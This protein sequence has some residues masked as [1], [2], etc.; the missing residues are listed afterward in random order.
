LYNTVTSSLNASTMS[1]TPVVKLPEPKTPIV[2]SKTYDVGDWKINTTTSSI[3]P[4]SVADDMQKDLGIP[5]PEI[6]FALNALELVHSSGWTYRFDALDALK[7]V[8][9][10]ELEPGDGGV[11]VRYADEWAKNRTEPGT[12]TPMPVI[13]VM[14]PF[15]WT[16]TT[17]YTGH[18]PSSTEGSPAFKL[19]DPEEPTHKINMQ[20]LTRPDP[21]LFFSEIPL[22]EDELHDNGSSQLT[23]R[24]RVMPQCIF[25]L[26][27]FTLRVDNVLFRMFDTR[28]YHSLVGPRPL[29]VRETGGWE[30]PYD[31]IKKFL[32]MKN[33]LSPLTDTNFIAKSLMQ[34]PKELT[35]SKGADTGWRGLGTKTEVLYLGDNQ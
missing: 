29:I 32:P 14:K 23:V 8:K 4:A 35:Q 1:S 6:T 2:T 20:E 5:L 15:D 33:D 11:K 9:K 13:T 28:L 18:S 3:V 17:M 30:A 26:L 24:I 27:R 10:G 25:I 7:L 22:F 16:Y 34:F 21:I 12:T 19:A 31:D